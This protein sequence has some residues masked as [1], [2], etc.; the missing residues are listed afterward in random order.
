MTPSAQLSRE[1][2]AFLDRMRHAE[3]PTREDEERVKRAL[4]VAIATRVTGPG[5]RHAEG[6]QTSGAPAADSMGRAKAVVAKAGAGAWGS[7]LSLLVLCA[8]AL[9]AAGDGDRT[10]HRTPTPALVDAPRAMPGGILP[11]EPGT[12]PGAVSQDGERPAPDGAGTA[13]GAKPAPR[14]SSAAVPKRSV[15]S[16]FSA[17]VAL[18][19]RVQAALRR[20]DGARALR[21]LDTFRGAGQLLAERRAARVLALC[22]LGRVAEAQEVAAELLRADPSSL[23][24]A[25]IERSCANPSRIGG[26]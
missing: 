11:S 19:E 26:R 6:E 10:A 16:G 14:R 9:F 2:R 20:G 13:P 15:P 21:Q 24:S 5:Q 7:S 8:A 18:I 12:A 23:Q 25:T 17:E 1:A 3:D 4:D 22:S